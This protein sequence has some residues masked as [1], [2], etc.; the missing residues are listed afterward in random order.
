MA[1]THTGTFSAMVYLGDMQ[2]PVTAEVEYTDA[3]AESVIKA[4]EEHSGEG[5]WVDIYDIAPSL[6]IAL[7]QA[8]V[9]QCPDE[10]QMDADAL[11]FDYLEFPKEL[12]PSK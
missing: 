1:N 6:A 11:E 12:V 2:Y 4:H 3:E 9:E 8:F 10:F 5:D 7:K